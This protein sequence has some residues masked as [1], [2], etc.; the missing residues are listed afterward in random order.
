[1]SFIIESCREYCAKLSTNANHLLNGSNL[2]FPNNTRHSAPPN[3]PAICNVKIPPSNAWSTNTSSGSKP[4]QNWLQPL[5]SKQIDK[6]PAQ[7]TQMKFSITA[8]YSAA[9]AI[10]GSFQTSTGLRAAK[11]SSRRRR[12]A[13]CGAVFSDGS[14]AFARAA[15]LRIA[16][17]N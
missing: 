5:L 14:P 3:I 8:P 15:T 10:S 2:Q 11:V 4:T 16:P 7:R 1:M 12:G 17:M 13:K 9:I 6:E